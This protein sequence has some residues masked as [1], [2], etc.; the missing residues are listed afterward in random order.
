M[1]NEQKGKS[2]AERRRLG[3]ATAVGVVVVLLA[4]IVIARYVMHQSQRGI[5]SAQDFYFASNFLKESRE[6]YYIDPQAGKFEIQLYNF[7]DVKRVS[8]EDIKYKVS[9]SSGGTADKTEGTL[10]KGGKRIETI[11]V[12]PDAGTDEIAVTVQTTAPYEKELAATFHLQSG[13]SYTLENK[14][15]DTAAVLDMICTDH[16]A[17]RKVTLKLPEGVV[18]DATDDSVS[19]SGGDF[20][21]TFPENGLY[22]V[23]LLKSNPEM[24][25]EV[26][27]QTIFSDEID[28]RSIF[29]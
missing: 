18:P 15:G 7:A 10:A 9:V 28:L 17:G 4:G 2:D 26:T 12:S 8:T 21:Y 19:R 14:A 27:A 16:T 23:V 24:N 20:I 1:E 3:L 13:D 6:D 25:G 11:A 5:L 29:K 22:S